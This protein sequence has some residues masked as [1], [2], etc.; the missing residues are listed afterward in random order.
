[1]RILLFSPK[2]AGN[3]YY[4]PGMNAFRMYQNLTPDAGIEL[5]LAHGYREQQRYKLFKEQY[6][7]SDIENKNIYLGIKF[8]FRAKKWID[9]NAHKFDIVHCLTSFHHSFMFSYWFEKKG[10]PVIIKIGQSDH[11]GFDE[12]SIKSKLLG[13]HRFR[14]KNANEIS[15]YVSISKEI[16]SKLLQAGIEQKRIYNL[17]NGVDTNQFYP[18]NYSEK[19]MIRNELHI[20]DKFTVIFTGAFSER[21]NPLLIAQAF[22]KFKDRSDIQLLL[23]GPDLDGG[24]QRREILKIIR[25]Q[26]I[27]NILL[28]GFTPTIAPYYR[29]SDLFVL[30]SSQE[31]FSNSMLEAQASGL[32]A[33]VTRIS[34]SED[35]I[36]EDVNGRFIEPNTTSL[37]EAM[38][39][40]FNNFDIL[41]KESINARK[42]IVDNY[43]M[44]AILNSYLKMFRNQIV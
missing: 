15:G 11:T 16:R 3:H 27:K 39:Y 35:I 2:G 42:I 5:Y 32:P 17:P 9:R 30:P 12:N 25:E 4:G 41:S 22:K 28:R 14:L 40:Y 29:A 6:F 19:L 21:K 1:M 13:L 38:N 18:V 36:I 34:G 26:K 31:G 43:S 24:A 20:E 23:I 7:I 33:V 8:L 44:N 10:V 37:Y